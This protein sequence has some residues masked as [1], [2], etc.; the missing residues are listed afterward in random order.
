MGLDIIIK[1]AID[2]EQANYESKSQNSIDEM[3]KR[4]ENLLKQCSAMK[5]SFELGQTLAKTI[6]EQ[7]I[8]DI[9]R[10]L[11]R[12]IVKDI[13]EDIV[14][15]Q[16]INHEA[17]QKQAYEER[18]T[19]AKTIGEQIITDIGRLLRRRIVKDINEDIVKSQFINHEAIQKQ[20]YEES[21]SQ[22]NG[23]NILKYVYDI[24]RYFIDL[25]LK[26]IKTT[27]H[28][29]THSHTLNFQHL[30][31]LT[32]NKA[33]E[34]VR[35]SN[36][37]D[38]SRLKNDVE[39]AILSL[40]DLKLEKSVDGALF[41]VFSLNNIIS[42]PIQDIEPFKQG[43][44]SICD[45]YNDIE[46]RVADLTKNI[47]AEAFESCKGS[48]SKR[49][50]CQARCPGCGAKCSKPEPHGDEEVEAWHD[51]C[52]KCSPNNCTCQR[53]N[54]SSVK[55]H[56]TTYHLASAFHGWTYQ[57]SKKPCLEL[58][59][60]HWTTAGVAVLKSAQS[61][62]SSDEKRE[63][64]DEYEYIFP[65]AKY[66]NTNYPAWYNNLKKLST[67][68]DGCKESIPPPDQRRAW[69]VVRHTLV[70]RYKN[71]MVDNK[72]YD[73]KLY[74]SNVESLPADFEPNWK[75]IDFA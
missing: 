56:E 75:D 68:G 37:E 10:L 45:Y 29:V 52:E 71:K 26:E 4:K 22:A 49:L 20:A 73:N 8:T 30:I 64:D 51:S 12:R 7:I 9:G 46:K 38:T 25:S 1:K 2:M 63:D 19:L 74:P 48:I 69:M 53:S 17:I 61:T 58:C 57:G 60:Q 39:N 40:P 34:V 3:E 72:E 18:Q 70:N 42:M 67:V 27:L 36:Y 16:F 14:K 62:D 23:E 15:S 31:I 5:D 54:S 32:L 33:K 24:N 11:R 35:Q 43:F 50:G 55:T 47:K 44:S 6:G 59:Y 13:N 66:F 21:I 41:K 65:R 28:A